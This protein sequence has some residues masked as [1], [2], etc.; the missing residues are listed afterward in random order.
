MPKP[1]N[2]NPKNS[3]SDYPAVDHALQELADVLAEIAANPNPAMPEERG[4][5]AGINE[6]AKGGGTMPERS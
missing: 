2:A 6:N 1:P 3:I 4:E 5:N